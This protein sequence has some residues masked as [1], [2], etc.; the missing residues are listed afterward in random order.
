[1]Y[2]MLCFPDRPPDCLPT[3]Y[4]AKVAPSVAE[5]FKLLLGLYRFFDLQQERQWQQGRWAGIRGGDPR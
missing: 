2:R 3:D 5:D 1:M 4:Y